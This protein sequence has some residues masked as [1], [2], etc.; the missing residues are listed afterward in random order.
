MEISTEL[1]EIGRLKPIKIL[2]PSPIIITREETIMS[3]LSPLESKC[4]E[5]YIQF[6]E[7]IW[8]QKLVPD[9]Q[10]SG[11]IRP[12]PFQEPAVLSIHN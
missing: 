9:L 7:K 12:N 4:F 5:S 11:Y 8:T 1:S 6:P 10:D 2:D 3:I